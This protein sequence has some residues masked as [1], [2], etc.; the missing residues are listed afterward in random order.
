MS[1][2]GSEALITIGS[3]LANVRR[4]GLGDGNGR[5]EVVWEDLVLGYM[6]AFLELVGCGGK[7]RL[8]ATLLEV[9]FRVGW[10]RSCWR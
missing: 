4:L 1:P 5:V 7:W 3:M 6:V 10:S 2:E 8:A 9:D